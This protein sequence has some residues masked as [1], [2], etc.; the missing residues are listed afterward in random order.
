MPVDAGSEGVAA[1]V[2][3]VREGFVED[4]TSSEPW[5]P[6]A[7]LSRGWCEMVKQRRACGCWTVWG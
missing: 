6:F 4:G 3:A 5:W 1:G 7:V 2:E